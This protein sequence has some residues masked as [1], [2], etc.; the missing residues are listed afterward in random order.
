[1]IRIKSMVDLRAD[2][3]R[4]ASGYRRYAH[5]ALTGLFQVARGLAGG[6][7]ERYRFG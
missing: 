5:A 7:R 6:A 4:R 3:C 1:M 2:G